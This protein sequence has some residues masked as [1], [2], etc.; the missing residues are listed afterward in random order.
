MYALNA[1]HFGKQLSVHTVISI[2]EFF[3]MLSY[4]TLNKLCIVALSLQCFY[5]LKNY[6]HELKFYYDETPCICKLSK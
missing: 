5:F 2:T 4:F 3:E 1:S 6:H